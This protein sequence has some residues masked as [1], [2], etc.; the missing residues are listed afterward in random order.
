[1]L[2]TFLK[3]NE[4]IKR[5]KIR[6]FNSNVM[7]VLLDGEEIWKLNM[8]LADWKV[9]MPLES[10]THILAIKT[11]NQE[12]YCKCKTSPV[13]KIIKCRR[14]R[15]LWHTLRKPQNYNCQLALTGTPEGMRGSTTITWHK[16]AATKLTH[17]GSKTRNETGKA[18]EDAHGLKRISK[19]IHPI[20]KF[21]QVCR[22]IVTPYEYIAFVAATL[23]QLFP[24]IET[25]LQVFFIILVWSANSN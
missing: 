4:Y 10:T 16:S 18:A 17:L 19:Y 3:S 5:T 14:W 9:F 6:I 25:L 22:K 13:G 20:V 2:K 24:C 7:A 23:N 15:C 8:T 12:L 11:S 1:M 21:I